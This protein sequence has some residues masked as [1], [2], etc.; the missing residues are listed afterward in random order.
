MIANIVYAL[1]AVTSGLCT[2]L[3]FRSYRKSKVRLLMW[4]A[5]CFGLMTINNILVYVDLI[6]FPQDD[7]SLQRAVMGLLAVIALLFGM[8]WETA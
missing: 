8:V 5:V 6:V 3:L 7:L 2:V 4:S 1:C